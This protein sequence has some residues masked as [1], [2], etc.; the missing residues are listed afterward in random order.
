MQLS[1]GEFQAERT[2]IQRSKCTEQC[3]RSKNKRS[4]LRTLE[5]AGLWKPLPGFCCFVM[6]GKELC[7]V[8]E[9]KAIAKVSIAA[10]LKRAQTAAEGPEERF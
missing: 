9:D 3:G 10:A 6:R 7:G 8:R 1:R 5:A 2:A 4:F